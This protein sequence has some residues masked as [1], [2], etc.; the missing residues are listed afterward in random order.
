VPERRHLS[1]SKSCCCRGKRM[2]RQNTL[3]TKLP[4]LSSFAGLSASHPRADYRPN[5]CNILCSQNRNPQAGDILLSEIILFMRRRAAPRQPSEIF[6]GQR[7][8]SI[9]LTRY[10]LCLIVPGFCGRTSRVPSPCPRM[11]YLNERVCGTPSERPTE[12]RQAPQQY[13]RTK[14]FR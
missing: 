7:V 11:R 2:R 8:A 13:Q 10:R 9:G 6:F 1:G 4:V 3:L 12:R 5:T 14:S